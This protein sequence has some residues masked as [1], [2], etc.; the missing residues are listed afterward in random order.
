MFYNVVIF[1]LKYYA[2]ML[3]A[4]NLNGLY[5]KLT[6]LCLFLQIEDDA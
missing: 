4:N 3:E 5:N 2:T 6:I 1:M